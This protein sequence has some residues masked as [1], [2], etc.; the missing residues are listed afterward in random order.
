[1]RGVD[2]QAVCLE[3]RLRPIIGQEGENP[4][5]HVKIKGV[6]KKVQG[7]FFHEEA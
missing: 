4:R 7:R 6:K 2:Y 5:T 3:N 1:M